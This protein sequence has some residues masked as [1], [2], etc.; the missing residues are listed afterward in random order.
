MIRYAQRPAPALRPRLALGQAGTVHARIAVVDVNGRPIRAS[1]SVNGVA[2]GQTDSGGF[3]YAQVPTDR[4][5]HV[6]VQKDDHVV[7]KDFS[8]PGQEVPTA[9]VQIPVCLPQP[10]LTTAEIAALLGAAAMTGAGFYFKTD[11]LKIT[12]EV[13]F[14]AAAFTAIYRLS[15]L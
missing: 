11:A 8:A 9:Y 1:V 13:L 4:P 2:A 7:V 5:F 12:G 6:L 15:C 10:I 3:A 14:G